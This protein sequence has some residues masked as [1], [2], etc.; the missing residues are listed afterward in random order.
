MEPYTLNRQFLPQNAIDVFDSII[1]TERY[2]GDSDVELVVP[3]TADSLS[4]L[5]TGMFLGIPESDEIMI[6]ET[7]SIEEGK[8]K[9]IGISLLQWLN[10]RFIRTSADHKESAWTITGGPAGWVLWAI[11]WNMCHRDSPFLNG[12][13]PMGVPNPEK[14]II[15][16]LELKDYDRSGPNVTQ[17]VSFG[18]VYDALKEVAT[19]YKLGM[20]ITLESATDSAYVIGFRSYKGVDRT[21]DQSVTPP[22][23]FSPQMDSLTNIT[24]LKSIATLKTWVYTYAPSVTSPVPTTPGESF[25]TGQENTGF[26][27]R[28]LMVT[29]SEIT[30]DSIV[31]AGDAGKLLELLNTK[32]NDVLKANPFIEVVDGEIVPTSQYKYG[33]DY[34]LGD[35]VEAQGNSGIVTKYRVT[36][37][38][39]AQDESGE[40]AYP[41]VAAIE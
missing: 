37:Y 8:I 38:I 21:S 36:E 29:I 18:P 5:S 15:P 26:D 40:K 24:E 14:F 7:M 3:L 19:S 2:Y 35:I 10:N 22:V 6:L 20:Q 12:S 4:K 31:P 30:N 39:R 1:W 11:V 23:R 9:F 32:A 17:V 28:A 13:V 27:L 41:T 34:N 33:R 25:V 16:G